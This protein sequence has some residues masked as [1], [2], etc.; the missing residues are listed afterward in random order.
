V[1]GKNAGWYLSEAGGATRLAEKGATFIVR[2]DGEVISYHQSGWWSGSV[3]S[4]AAHPGETVVVSERP[5][6]GD[7][8]TGRRSMAAQ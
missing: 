6:I 7:T 1:P 3:L 4:T 8:C 5:V 2:A